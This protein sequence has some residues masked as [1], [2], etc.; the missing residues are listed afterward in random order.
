MDDYFGEITCSGAPV[1]IPSSLHTP[2]SQKWEARI[3]YA[4]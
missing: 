2:E 3:V 1:F 4:G